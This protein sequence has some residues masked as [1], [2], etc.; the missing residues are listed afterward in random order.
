MIKEIFVNMHVKDLEKTKKFFKAL[1]FTFNPQ[2]TDEKAASLILGD[3]IYAM[4]ITEKFF[5]TFIPGREISNAKKVTE[6]LNAL[7]VDS[8]KKVDEIINKAIKAGG[9][10]YRTASDYGWM[11]SRSFEDLDGHIWEILHLDKSK[12]PKEMADKK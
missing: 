6:T 3:N 2:F 4:L 5:E 10:E 12:M 1:G 9:K 7:S 11:Y 8:R